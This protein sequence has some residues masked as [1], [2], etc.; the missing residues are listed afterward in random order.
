MVGLLAKVL[1][2]VSEATKKKEAKLRTLQRRELRTILKLFYQEGWVDFTLSDLEYMYEMSPKTCFKFVCDDELIGATFALKLE[3]DVCYPNSSIIAERFRKT[4]KYHEEILQYAEYLKKISRY[5]VM[6]SAQWL[7]DLYE[8]TM[9]YSAKAT[10]KRYHLT[11]TAPLSPDGYEIFKLDNET[12]ASTAEYLKSIY[13]SERLSIL[14]HGLSNGFQ[15]FGVIKEGK[16]QGFAMNRNLPKHIHVGPLVAENAKIAAL[17][18]SHTLNALPD[19][20]S[21]NIMI[22]LYDEKMAV[23]RDLRAAQFQ[24]EGTTMIKMTR[25]D[26]NFSEREAAIFSIYSHYLS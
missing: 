8:D 25:G 14:Q 9:G 10:I 26:E 7:V 4:V 11:K 2:K 17:L 13:H 12:L 1:V 21:T 6:Y 15:G 23:L 22:D 24:A 5:E 19:T 16:I 3:N 18:L 20:E